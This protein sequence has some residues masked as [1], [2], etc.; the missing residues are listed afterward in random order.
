MSGSGGTCFG[1]YKD[2]ETANSAAGRL[3]EQNPAWWVSAVR[4]NSSKT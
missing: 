4:L 2:R 1:I 3:K